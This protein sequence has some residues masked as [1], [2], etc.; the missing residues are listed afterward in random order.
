M[1]QPRAV[2]P[3]STYMVVRRTSQ[4]QFLLKPCPKTNRAWL[5][6]LAVAAHKTGVRVIWSTVM[7]NHHH[8]GV[9]DPHGNIS[10]FCRELHRLVAKYLNASYGRFENFWASG[11]VTLVRLED[12]AAVLDKLLYSLANPSSAD[13]VDRATHWPGVNTTPEQLCRTVRV[14]RPREFFRKDGPLPPSIDLEFVHPPGFEDLSVRQVRKLVADGLRERE[15]QARVARRKAGRRI[16]GRRAIRRQRWDESP[17][18]WAKRFGLK[19]RV[20]TKDKWRRIAALQRVRAF[21]DAYRVAL[22]RWRNGER[23]VCFPYGTNMMRLVHNVRCG[24]PPVPI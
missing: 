16:V 9:R 20:A 11:A 19:P 3:G 23:D 7:S 4:R 24:D 6:C 17:T 18:T 5:Y 12:P 1:T 21:I 2:Y 22:N 14:R 8:T 15:D 10:A 13:L